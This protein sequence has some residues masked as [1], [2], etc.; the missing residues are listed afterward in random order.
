MEKVVENITPNIYLKACVDFIK[1]WVYI[2][3]QIKKI[4][5][6]YQFGRKIL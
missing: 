3:W 4:P 2:P 6:S 5:I 1:S